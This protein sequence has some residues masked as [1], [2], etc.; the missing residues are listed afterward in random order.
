[1][2]EVTKLLTKVAIS[3]LFDWDR[4]P[5]EL[6]HVTIDEDGMFFAFEGRPPLNEDRGYWGTVEMQQIAGFVPHLTGK[7]K[8]QDLIFERPNA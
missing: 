1:M 8:W 3:E 4:I 2:T 7:F 5:P 6:D